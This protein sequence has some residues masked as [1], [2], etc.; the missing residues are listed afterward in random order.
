MHIVDDDIAY[1]LQSDASTTHNVD[2]GSAAI[3]GFVAV[4]Y[5]F[6]GELDEHVAREH[7][8]EWLSLNHSIS[9]SACPRSHGIVIR[10]VR[11][12]VILTTFAS[13]SILA[14]PYCTI[15]KALPV[16]WPIWITF[17]AVVDRV[18]S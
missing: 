10:R 2:I 3:E 18:T 17:P 15:C 13:M 12:N 11:H 14:K 8:P 9:E 6:L 4:E 16:V 7:N 1:V 5:E